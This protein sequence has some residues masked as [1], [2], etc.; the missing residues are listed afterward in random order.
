MYLPHEASKYVR[1]LRILLEDTGGR[2]VHQSCLEKGIQQWVNNNDLSAQIT[3]KSIRRGAYFLRL[4]LMQ[5][6]SYTSPSHVKQ[7]PREWRS[8]CITNINK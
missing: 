1:T 7:A 5:C 8:K 3:G 2:V 4:M 6:G